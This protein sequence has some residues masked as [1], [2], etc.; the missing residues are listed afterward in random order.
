MKTLPCAIWIAFVT[1]FSGPV[2]ADHALDYLNQDLNPDVPA[3]LVAVQD[4]PNRFRIHLEITC[5]SV[6]A[7]FCE[8]NEKRL[9]SLQVARCFNYETQELIEFLGLN[10]V[11]LPETTNKK[12][13]FGK[14]YAKTKSDLESDLESDFENFS[15]RRETIDFNE[16]VDHFVDAFLSV[17]SLLWLARESSTTMTL[18]ISVHEPKSK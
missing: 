4:A 2:L 10:V 15:T 11:R 12:G 6:V 18:P 17:Q 3:C 7:R 9:Q 16:S 14:R 13:F 5:S 1:A 8:D